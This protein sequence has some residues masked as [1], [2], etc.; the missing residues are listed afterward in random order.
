MRFCYY[1]V[2]ERKLAGLSGNYKKKKGDRSLKEYRVTVNR[3]RKSD[4]VMV[5]HK[6]FRNDFPG[7]KEG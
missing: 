7:C 3:S 2:M 1:L 4:I 6:P 5:E